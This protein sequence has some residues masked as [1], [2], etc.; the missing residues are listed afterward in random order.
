MT[1][2]NRMHDVNQTDDQSL[3]QLFHGEPIADAGFSQRVVRRVRVRIWVQRLIMPAA[4]LLGGVLA[5]AP[6]VDVLRVISGLADYVPVNL[7]ALA[8]TATP[9]MPAVVIAAALV[10]AALCFVPALED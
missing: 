8:S 6:L 3:E 7:T 2:S 10:V 9:S 1:F 5:Y 4:L